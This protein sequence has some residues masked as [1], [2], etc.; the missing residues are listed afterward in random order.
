MSDRQTM[1]RLSLTLACA[2]AVLAGGCAAPA[3]RN[4]G[5]YA[6]SSAQAQVYRFGPAQPSGADA[7]LKKGD[8]VVMLRREYGFS[9][10]MTEDGLTGYISNDF[11]IPTAPP[12]RLRPGG[13]F[14]G[15]AMPVPPLPPRGGE[16]PGVSSA[17]RS[18]LQTAPLFGADDL[19]PLPGGAKPGFR[20]PKPKPGFRVNVRGPEDS[21][22]PPPEPMAEPKLKSEQP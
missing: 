4:D 19:P 15:L 5:Y 11:I 14:G 7:V 13:S 12:D 16:M 1:R 3:G 22:Q 9:R 17:N 6:V 8:K 10:V 21:P 20:V 18:V 2:C